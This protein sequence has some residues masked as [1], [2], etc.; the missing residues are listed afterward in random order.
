MALFASDSCLESYQD[1]KFIQAINE[2]YFG[3][4]PGIN[5]L[6]NA[7]C[8][9]REP[10]ISNTKYYTGTSKKIY[11]RD[12]WN[13]QDLVCKQ[14]GFKTFSYNVIQQATLN[15]FTFGDYVPKNQK[16][17][18]ITKE[19]YRFK[20]E[21]NVSAIVAVYSDLIFSPEYTNEENFAV[22]LHE[23]GHNFQSA[24]N[25]PIFILTSARLLL[26]IACDLIQYGPFEAVLSIV[27]TS[28]L[29]KT[30]YNK[31]INTLASNQFISVVYSVTSAL[32][33]AFT[34][35]MGFARSVGNLLMAPV[36]LIINWC[37]NLLNILLDIVTLGAVEGYLGERFAD[38]FAASYGFG[39]ALTS[40]LGK[41]NGNGISYDNI[42]D[43][44]VGSIPIVSHLYAAACIPGM[45]L[46]GLVD[47]H[48][49]FENRAYSI[50][51]DLKADLNDPSLS[52]AMK[53]QL[54]KEI[55]EYEKYMTKYFEE[56]KKLKN[57]NVVMAYMQ[58]FV[59]NK[60][61]GDIKYKLSELLFKNGFRGETNKTKDNIIA[62]T[63]IL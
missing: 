60:C 35:I 16:Q 7:Y 19:G 27:K 18:E 50:V 36:N 59:Y 10:L 47:V 61:G 46:W 6:F 55:D 33:Y 48:P 34:R 24:T 53:K 30:E 38:G 40:A 62:D 3:R 17:I 25:K 14:F 39:E 15:S 22:F 26:G 51:N 56:S 45:L 43:D 42:I 58:D 23:I 29:A 32:L 57:P 52:P 21:C 44:A 12:M 2:V 8:D 9:W 28:N 41:F 13:F 20:P 1:K 37:Y 54:Q 49:S 63:K 11:N 31:V 5:S 4:T